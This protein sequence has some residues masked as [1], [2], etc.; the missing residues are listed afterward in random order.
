MVEV[1]PS[2]YAKDAL[3]RYD[4]SRSLKRGRDRN[5][6]YKRRMVLSRE[7]LKSMVA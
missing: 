1:R 5:A 2:K 4:I 7:N 6:D 3:S